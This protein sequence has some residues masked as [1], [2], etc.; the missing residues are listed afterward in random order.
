MSHT[1]TL[2]YTVTGEPT[3]HCA[4]CEQRIGNALRRLPGIRAVQASHRTQ[5]V[6]VTID[7]A[8]VGADQVQGKLE[9]LGYQVR[10]AEAVAP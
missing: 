10:T 6:R 8:Q 3:I 7:P 2:N 9:Q 4:G 1:E 5:Q